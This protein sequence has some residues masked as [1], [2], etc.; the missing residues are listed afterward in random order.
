MEKKKYQARQQEVDYSKVNQPENIQPNAPGNELHVYY[1]DAYMKER[2][3]FNSIF[4]IVDSTEDSPDIEQPVK[5]TVY[6]EPSADEYVPIKK[7]KK[8]KGALAAFVIIAIIGVAAAAVFALN[9]FG[10][11][12]L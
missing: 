2:E 1:N 8:V 11:I 3:R 4:G 6:V 12:T 5:E 10:I 7:Y 9:F